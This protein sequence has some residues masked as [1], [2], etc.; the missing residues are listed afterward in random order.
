VG[1]GAEGEEQADSV[2]SMEP[3][4]GLDAGLD[5]GATW[6]STRGLTWAPHGAGHK[7]R[8]QD[9]EIMT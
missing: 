6:G 9:P 4:V 7:T 2:L 8:S 5:M 1:G 3:N